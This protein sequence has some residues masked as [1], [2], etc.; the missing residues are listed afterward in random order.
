MARLKLEH[1]DQIL[2]AIPASMV[3]G[4]A[5]V[6]TY[7]LFSGFSFQSSF[8]Y[9]SSRRR[10]LHRINGVPSRDNR[11]VVEPQPLSMSISEINISQRKRGQFF[12][13][14]LRLQ[15]IYYPR[16]P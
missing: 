11:H 6:I 13:F 10:L 2:F 16:A 12:F 8:Y 3:T 9:F 14:H 1:I 7:Y 5:R 4:R 15:I